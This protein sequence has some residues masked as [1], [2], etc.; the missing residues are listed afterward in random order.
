MFE[1]DALEAV[2]IDEEPDF[3]L[4]EA[5]MRAHDSEIQSC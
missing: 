1:M 4:A 2:D 5:L 3:T